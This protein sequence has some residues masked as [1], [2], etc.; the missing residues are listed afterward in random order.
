MSEA[1]KITLGGQEFDIP[2]LPLGVQRKLEPVLR[3]MAQRATEA[4]V[5]GTPEAMQNAMASPENTDD[6]ELTVVIALAFI[7]KDFSP[8]KFDELIA[9]AQDRLFMMQTDLGEI[10][11]ASIVVAIQAGGK[12]L[13][14]KM[15]AMKAAMAPPPANPQTEAP[16]TTTP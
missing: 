5:E 4:K 8:P 15:A 2:L 13:G 3:R 10:L 1:A 12:R 16:P 14:E 7:D 9:K 6:A 11:A